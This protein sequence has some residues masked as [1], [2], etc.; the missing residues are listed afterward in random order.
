M[1]LS[2]NLLMLTRI[3]PLVYDLTEMKRCP[4]SND[5]CKDLEQEGPRNIT[6]IKI[7][8]EQSDWHEVD[9][10]CEDRAD[11][12]LI[13][14]LVHLWE[15]VENLANYQCAECDCHD[16]CK[17]FLLKNNDRPKHNYT[18]LENGLP[19]PN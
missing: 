5:N 3:N 19:H 10:E 1:I 8:F 18:S 15:Y 13:V 11:D 12:H 16:I 9:D 4:A 14:D 17:W 2:H 6:C 7:I